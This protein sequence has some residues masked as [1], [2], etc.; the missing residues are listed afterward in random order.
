V[1]ARTGPG[2]RHGQPVAL[3]IRA[4]LGTDLV[5][6]DGSRGVG[7]SQTGGLRHTYGRQTGQ[8]EQGKETTGAQ[9][10]HQ[11]SGMVQVIHKVVFLI[12]FRLARMSCLTAHMFRF[13]PAWFLNASFMVLPVY[14]AQSLPKVRKLFCRG[15]ESTFK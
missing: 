1:Q 8:Q 14:Q 15:K 13:K 5:P 2:R 4:G 3:V 7:G 11:L 10:R 9:T 6:R 12:Q